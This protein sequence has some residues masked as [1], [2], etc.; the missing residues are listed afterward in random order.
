M[1]P[2]LWHVENN[3]VRLGLARLSALVSPLDPASGLS[4]WRID[5]RP[6]QDFHPLQVELPAIE[7]PYAACDVDYYVRG[8]DLIVTYAERPERAMRSQIYWRAATHEPRG[9]IAAVELQAS[10]QTSLLDSCPRLA[11]RTDVTASEAFQ[12]SDGEREEFVAIAPP[13]ERSKTDD[14]SRRPHCY[15]FRLAS[16]EYSYAEMVL[17]ANVPQSELTCRREGP[18]LRVQLAHQLFAERLEKGVILRARVLG[19]MLDRDG[20]QAAAA[21]HYASFMTDELPLTT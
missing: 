15:L 4:R 8:G 2:H 10:V 9:A 14:R 7:P 3:A 17:P 20:D 1:P 16:G 13:S 5:D 6:L 11:T 18:N 19:V 12:L 21:A